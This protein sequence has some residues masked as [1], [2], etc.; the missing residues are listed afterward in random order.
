MPVSRFK[1][2]D[3]GADQLLAAGVT[4]NRGAELWPMSAGTEVLAA[5]KRV[6]EQ[7]T[8]HPRNMILPM[9]AFSYVVDAPRN[10]MFAD[11]G[12]FCSVARGLRIV[13][14]NHPIDSVTTSPYH[15]SDFYDSYLPERLRYQGPGNEFP[16]GYGR[17]RIGNDVW[18]GGH[19]I[20]RSGLRIGNGAVIASGSVVVKDVP[21]YAIVGGNPAKIIRMRF[22]VEIVQRFMDLQYWLYDPQCFRD[23]NMFDV[24]EFL[25]FMETRKA[26]GA[27][28]EFLPRRFFFNSGQL[29]EV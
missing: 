28:R 11:I 18:I 27:L 4:W 16:R 12:R 10:M 20:V 25:G 23:L 3:T 1:I 2:D 9:G 5:E 14:G 17:V 8:R 29:H 26:E 13:N 15:F 6:F 7:F 21:D 24:E 19:C 22:P